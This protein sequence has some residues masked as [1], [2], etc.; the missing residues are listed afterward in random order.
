IYLATTGFDSPFTMQVFRSDNDGASWMAPVNGSPNG[1][2]E[3]YPPLA[4]DNFAGVGRGDVYLAARRFSGSQGIYVYRSSDGGAS[5]GNGVI[6]AAPGNVSGPR[7]VG[8]P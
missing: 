3:E 5:F 1:G 8:D 4:V 7:I 6:V 2:S